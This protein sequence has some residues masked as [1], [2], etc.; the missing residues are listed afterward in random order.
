MHGV[1]RRIEVYFSSHEY[2]YIYNVDTSLLLSCTPLNHKFFFFLVTSVGTRAG[3]DP[4]KPLSPIAFPHRD[5]GGCVKSINLVIPD[6]G[7]P[8]RGGSKSF[9]VFLFYVI[10]LNCL[11]NMSISQYNI[12]NIIF[13]GIYN[14]TTHNIIRTR[15]FG[16]TIWQQNH[17]IRNDKKK[18]IENECTDYSYTY[19]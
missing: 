6:D 19:R 10:I 12:L 2:I 1:L 14:I 5:S 8:W 7:H 13:N 4:D 3:D 18:S 15:Y 16:T 11:Y 17:V 9:Y